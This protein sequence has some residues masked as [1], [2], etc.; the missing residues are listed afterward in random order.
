MIHK[1][2]VQRKT[3]KDAVLVNELLVTSGREFLRIRSCRTK[4]F[5]EESFKLFRS[6]TVSKISLMQRFIMT[7]KRPIYILELCQCVTENYK[8]KNVFNRQELLWIQSKFPEHM[9]KLGFDLERGEKGST[10][11]H[12][13][14]QEFKKQTLEKEIDFLEKKISLRKKMN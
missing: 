13:E 5:F 4:R 6:D 10:R 3:R 2:R 1:K 11:E 9:Q 12:I 7:K 8:G 14:T